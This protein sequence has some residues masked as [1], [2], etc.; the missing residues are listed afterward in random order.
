[1]G[2]AA[3][4]AYFVYVLHLY[5]A[6]R[7]FRKKL[8]EREIEMGNAD[9]QTA[10]VCFGYF[11]IRLNGF[12]S[13]VV[14]ILATAIAAFACYLLVDLTNQLISSESAPFSSRLS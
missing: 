12:T 10:S 11:K 3:L 13:T 4:L 9:F 8:T 1:M 7:Q 14:I 5:L 2:V 6:T